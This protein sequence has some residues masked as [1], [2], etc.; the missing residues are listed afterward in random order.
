VDAHVCFVSYHELGLKGRN[1]S[2][3]ERRL[4]DNLRFLLGDE[5]RVRRIQGRILVEDY[6]FEDVSRI[7]TR[8]AYVPGVANVRP[9]WCAGRDLGEMG[10]IALRALSALPIQP[11]TFRVTAKRSNTDFELTSQ[12]VNEQIGSFL[13][14]HTGMTVDLTD[15]QVDVR[16]TIVGG[17]SFISV[18][19]LEGPGG[20]PVGSSATLLSLLS[21]GFD[22]PVAT[23]RMMRRGA[24]CV[25]LH[26]S[27]A[28][29]VADSSTQQVFEIGG[30]LARTGGLSRIYSVPFGAVQR[31]ISSTVFPDLRILVYRRV[32]MAVAQELARIEHAKALITGE[33]LGQVASQ[34]LENMLATAAPSTLEVFRPLIGD[35]KHDIIATAKR[36]GTFDLSAQAAEDCCTLFMP[37]SPET[38]VTVE[39]LDEA[40]ASLDIARF[41]AQCIETIRWNDYPCN[42]YRAPACFPT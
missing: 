9:S 14:E 28:P 19:K 25:G 15:P 40:C 33:S 26:F 12:Q 11:V 20:L 5:A 2:S 41:V 30:I 1:R 17:R 10:H 13:C 38:H 37:R 16:I 32:M 22:S 18:E 27:G 8:I 42:H 6:R 36:I 21:S 34:T 23:W 7:A 35:D 31:E 24:T 39:R 29:E 4:V 3:F